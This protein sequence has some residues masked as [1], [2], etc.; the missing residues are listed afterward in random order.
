MSARPSS[1]TQDRPYEIAIVGND[2]ILAALPGRAIQLTHALLAAGWDLVVPVS[3]GEELL[4]EHA[5]RQLEQRGAR[6][7]V[8]C[9]C[10]LVRQRLLAAGHEIV[11]HL[12]ST[13]APPVATARYLRALQPEVAMRLTYLGACPG[14]EDDALD[15]RMT[16]SELLRLLE[17]RGI[18]IV[19]QPLVFESTVPPD[20]RRHWS[21]PGGAPSE[22]AIAERGLEARFVVVGR[23]VALDIAD[24]LLT[25]TRS[26]LDL[27][28]TL[29][30]AC[31]GS[32]EVHH[33]QSSREEVAAL[34]PPRSMLPVVDPDPA[35]SLVHPLARFVASSGRTPAAREVADAGLRGISPLRE[36]VRARAERR[37]IA[38][39]PTHVG[40]TEAGAGA[41][42]SQSG[43][44]A[45]RQDREIAPQPR[46]RSMP[47]A[48]SPGRS[49]TTGVPIAT[50][51]TTPIGQPDHRADAPGGEPTTGVT[52]TEGEHVVSGVA[53]PGGP[54]TM[55][56]PVEPGADAAPTAAAPVPQPLGAA[57]TTLIQEPAPALRRTP[58]YEMR[59][60]VRTRFSTPGDAPRI[61]RAYIA[62]RARTRHV[63]EPIDE[64]QLAPE[65]PTAVDP[66]VIPSSN[67]GG[68]Y[69]AATV[70][71]LRAVAD[72]I[73]PDESHRPHRRRGASHHRRVEPPMPVVPPRF[74]WWLFGSVLLVVAISVTLALL[75]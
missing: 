18:S 28:Q 67:G 21:L 32:V 29:G 56:L 30:C 3:W 12:M 6:A 11:P 57:E 49:S 60:I 48:R 51:A 63:G 17:A 31:A 52:R 8:F 58:T 73:P 46:N 47:A 25:G 44:P 27:A 34:E 38:I 68:G 16:P 65:S 62:L 13:V 69:D 36:A 5:L 72:L 42:V 15:A 24:H 45:P 71:P 70:A 43:Q 22:T 35:I 1:S 61:P 74:G 41:R 59:R 23:D 19:Q 40:P 64:P 7:T 55:P 39:T 4:A 10:P 33:V 20:R 9:A 26:L 2:L 54:V 66:V 14:A 37:R 75:R 50:Q 53:P